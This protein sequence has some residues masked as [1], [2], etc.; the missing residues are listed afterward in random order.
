MVIR[1]GRFANRP[2]NRWVLGYFAAIPQRAH[3]RSPVIPVV[4][5]MCV[6]SSF[7]PA[8]FSRPF[9]HN[10]PV[11][12]GGRK[13]GVCIGENANPDYPHQRSVTRSRPQQMAQTCGV[14]GN[15]PSGKF[16]GEMYFA[17]T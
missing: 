4:L 8:R 12:A 17:P 5:I 7:L 13:Y 10:I 2:Y 6:S 14:M 3:R 16:Q 15:I 1:P 9:I 11:P